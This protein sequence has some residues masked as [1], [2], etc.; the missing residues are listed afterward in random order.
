MVNEI[1][2]SILL[3]GNDVSSDSLFKSQLEN[4]GYYVEYLSSEQELIKRVI[5]KDHKI[6]LII[7]SDLCNTERRVI[8]ENIIPNINIPSIIFHK[9]IDKYSFL[10]DIKS[11][12]NHIVKLNRRQSNNIHE[13]DELLEAF[14]LHEIICDKNGKA[15]NFRYLDADTKFLKRINKTKEEIIGK[16]A[17]ELFPNTESI[18]IETFGRVALSGNPEVLMHYSIEFN[19][20]YEARI[21][22]PEKGKFIAVFI[23]VNKA[24]GK[25]ICPQLMRRRRRTIAS[26]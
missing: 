20:I 23:D 11:N 26:T 8:S 21:Y 1:P 17:L 25:Y 18:W 7:I 4:C 16:T 5:I 12:I 6:D 19:T 14:A 13:S 2:I 22:S 9:S 24:K 3:V 15:I 10:S